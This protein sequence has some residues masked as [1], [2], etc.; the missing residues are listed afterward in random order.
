M[1]AVKKLKIF[2]AWLKSAG[3][4]QKP[5]QL[6]GMEFCFAREAVDKM[7]G[8]S[9]GII[10]D[11][12]GLGKTILML[13]T[14]ICEKASGGGTGQPTLVILPKALIQQWIKIF[15]KVSTDA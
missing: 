15:K 6:S 5:H 4:D 12:M 7:G 13:G 8:V 9:G 1:N 11:E 14:I 2:Q 3:L 10:A